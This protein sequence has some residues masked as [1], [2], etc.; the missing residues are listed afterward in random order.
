M[1]PALSTGARKVMPDVRKL[2]PSGR[3]DQVWAIG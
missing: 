1:E 2:S 3:Y